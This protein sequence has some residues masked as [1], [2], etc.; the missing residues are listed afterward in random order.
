MNVIGLKNLLLEKPGVSLYYIAKY[1]K[2]EVHTMQ[3]VLRHWE[4]KGR[5]LC[6]NCQNGC[7]GCDSCPLQKLNDKYF[8]VG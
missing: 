2:S 1:F 6:V 7:G 3:V 4:K 8:W 5:L